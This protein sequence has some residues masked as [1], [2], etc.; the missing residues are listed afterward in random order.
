MTVGC[1]SP[2]G[3]ST[4]R[5]HFRALTGASPLQY[6]KQLRLQQARQLMLN[7]NLDAG[8]AALRVAT[9][10]VTI[11]SR[12]QPPLRCSAAARYR[13]D[14]TSVVIETDVSGARR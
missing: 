1:D 5:R 8:S 3:P 11:Q 13:P 6:Q 4:F 2:I 12:T 7:E 9:K 14:E 10:P